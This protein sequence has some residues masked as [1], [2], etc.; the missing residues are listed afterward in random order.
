MI[1]YRTHSRKPTGLDSISSS[2]IIATFIIVF[3]L[4]MPQ[5]AG[6]HAGKPSQGPRGPLEHR[7]YNRRSVADAKNRVTDAISTERIRVENDKTTFRHGCNDQEVSTKLT[8]L[9]KRRHADSPIRRYVPPSRRP[10]LIAT[11]YLLFRG[12]DTRVEAWNG[13]GLASPSVRSR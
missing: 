7:A 5:R 11:I 6:G 3:I 12:Q 8:T 1:T 2:L 4:F 9:C 13:E 10:I